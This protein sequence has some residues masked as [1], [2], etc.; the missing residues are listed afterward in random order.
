MTGTSDLP[1]TTCL[2]AL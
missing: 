2:Q 1:S